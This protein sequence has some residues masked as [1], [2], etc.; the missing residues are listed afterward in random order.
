M[1]PRQSQ[2]HRSD[3]STRGRL[4]PTTPLSRSPHG[5]NQLSTTVLG[6]STQLR[7][8]VVWIPHDAEHDANFSWCAAP[9]SR[10]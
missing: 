6:L 7:L 8:Q 10:Q 4:E 3:S 9:S 1:A 2:W 5:G